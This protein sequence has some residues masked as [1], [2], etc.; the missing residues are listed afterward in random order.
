MPKVPRKE[1][2]VAVAAPKLMPQ[3]KAAALTIMQRPQE[4]DEDTGRMLLTKA[5][6]EAVDKAEK[7]KTEIEMLEK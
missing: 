3:L 4:V 2:Q 1:E 5:E 7:L 6:Q